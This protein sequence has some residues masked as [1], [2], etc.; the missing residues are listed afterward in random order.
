MK[1]WWTMLYQMHKDMCATQVMAVDCPTIL[2]SVSNNSFIALSHEVNKSLCSS[3]ASPE[4][5]NAQ[6]CAMSSLD[7]LRVG[8]DRA[9]MSLVTHVVY[10]HVSLQ[11]TLASGIHQN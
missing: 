9:G 6:P 3:I 1:V 5:V 2:H 10:Q 4:A 8:T 7:S 11:R